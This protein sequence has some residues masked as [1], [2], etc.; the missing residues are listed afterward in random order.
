MSIMNKT[1]NNTSS[2]YATSIAGT[3]FNAT[4]VVSTN[5]TASNITGNVSAV[6][7]TGTTITAGTLYVLTPIWLKNVYEMVTYVSTNSGTT[8]WSPFTA[9]YSYGSIFYIPRDYVQSANFQV[10][11]KNIPTD[12]TKTYTLTLVYYQPTALFYASTAKVSDTTGTNFLLG[13][14]TT[15]AAPLWNGGTPVVSSAPNLIMQQFSIISI[16]TSALVYSR[17]VTSS[18]NVSTVT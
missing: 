18:V 7:V 10:F 11:I 5:I 16:P 4:N 6:A 12:T 17:Y 15:Y 9:D 8:P 13:T 2:I 14:S 1:T 3:T